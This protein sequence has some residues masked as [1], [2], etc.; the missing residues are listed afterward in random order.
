MMPGAFQRS[1]ARRQPGRIRMLFQHDPKEPVGVWERIAEDERGLFVAG[2][3]VAG[4]G[5]AETL[6]SLIA[7]GAIDGLSIGFRTVR[8]AR[9]PA[10]G[11]RRLY[12]I[13]L[14]EVSIVTFPMLDAA[15]IGPRLG[16]SQAR[17]ARSLG[18]AIHQLQT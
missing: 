9:N 16:I 14:W 17:L 8:A 7:A 5:R 10:D 13:D 12:Q 6:K 15:R 11:V 4:V 18:A 1:L 3:L 2:R